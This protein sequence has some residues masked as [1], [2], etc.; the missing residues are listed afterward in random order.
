[1]QIGITVPD[2]ATDE[3]KARAFL[4]ALEA[5]TRAH[6]ALA[7]AGRLPDL[8]QM[9]RTGAVQW[10]PEPPGQERFDLA[11]TVTAR[12]WGDCDDLAPW[13]AAQLR[14][15]GQDPK[16]KAVVKRSGPRTWHAVVRRG[17][18]S[19]D[20]PSKAAGME[21]Y[22]RIKAR[23]GMVPPLGPTG[24]AMAV[25]PLLSSSPRGVEAA[26]QGS[27]IDEIM[28]RTVRGSQQVIG[29]ACS[30]QA[31]LQGQR[32]AIVGC[33]IGRTLSEAATRAHR[34]HELHDGV[35][36]APAL[37]AALPFAA[38]V[39][40][41]LI[42]KFTGGGAA[43]QQASGGSG[44]GGGGRIHVPAGGGGG[45]GYGPVIVRF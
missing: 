45:Y 32:G 17:D 36:F 8:V 37:A 4:A 39:A 16:A 34:V 9:V 12:G 30:V 29:Y 10:R 11:S 33:G 3:D 15:T 5:S 2:D 24:R 41:P 25:T 18:G 14:H 23:G 7:H 19:I 28:R 40:A 38:Q 42:N 21:A 13:W 35:G 44:G 27:A 31:P 6:E 20:D 1:M 22:K 43:P 26:Q